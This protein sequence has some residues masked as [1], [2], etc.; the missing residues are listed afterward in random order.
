MKPEIEAESLIMASP[1]WLNWEMESGRE[2]QLR[3]VEVRWRVQVER[4]QPRW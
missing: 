2:T 1:E 3:L 4:S